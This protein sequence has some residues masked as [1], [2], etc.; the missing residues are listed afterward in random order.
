MSDQSAPGDDRDR[1]RP[2]RELP[3]DP[4]AAFFAVAALC[5]ACLVIGF[6]LGRTL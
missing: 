6:V 2:A 3:N 1:D 5:I 4:R